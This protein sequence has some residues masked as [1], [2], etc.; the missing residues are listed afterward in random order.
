MGGPLPARSDQYS[1]LRM[2]ALFLAAEKAATFCLLLRKQS[3]E[4]TVTVKSGLLGS[5]DGN[6]AIGR[7]SV[8]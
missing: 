1:Q 5:E 4:H 6:S 7:V 2:W 8:R 3:H